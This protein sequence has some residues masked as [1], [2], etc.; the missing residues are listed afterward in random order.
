[1]QRCSQHES[2]VHKS[3]SCPRPVCCHCLPQIQEVQH[4][5][6]EFFA[7]SRDLRRLLHMA[8]ASD[9]ALL[10]AHMPD[11]QPVHLQGHMRYNA[12]VYAAGKVLDRMTTVARCALEAGGRV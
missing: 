7:R 11:S 10:T 8:V 12:A 6:F 1:M 2:V 9:A 5:R 3:D 4:L